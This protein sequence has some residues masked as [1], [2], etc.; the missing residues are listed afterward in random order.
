SMNA[1]S[2]NWGLYALA[3]KY[4][5]WK[6]DWEQPTYAATKGFIFQNTFADIERMLVVMEENGTKPEIEC[7]DMGHLYNIKGMQ[8][9]GFVKGKPYLQFVMGINGAI[10]ANVNELVNMKDTADRLFGVGGYE[11]SAFG[12]GRM[13]YPICTTN[14]FLGGHV[15][16]GM[17]D[18]L[19]LG[20]GQMAKSN[21]ELVEKMVR[22][23]RE[24][25][26]EPATPDEGREILGTTKK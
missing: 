15:R 3:A 23:M 26:F 20:K 16:V 19:W 10:G 8:M 17:E 24:F 6:F 14:L 21:A 25:D 2:I 4:K 7:Y 11:W 13:E 22:I 18:N 5:E 12:A 1:G 9:Q